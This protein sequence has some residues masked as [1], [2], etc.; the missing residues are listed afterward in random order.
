[1]KLSNEEFKKIVDSLVKNTEVTSE[2]VFETIWM[3]EHVLTDLVG[4]KVTFT[5]REAFLIASTYVFGRE[6]Q[7]EMMEVKQ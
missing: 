7:R 3:T 5:P 6:E 2:E 4:G 1:M